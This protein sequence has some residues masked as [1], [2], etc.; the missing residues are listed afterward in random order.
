MVLKIRK[1]MNWTQFPSYDYHR[2]YPYPF[3]HV[4]TFYQIFYAKFKEHKVLYR[5]LYVV[6]VHFSYLFYKYKFLINVQIS[7]TPL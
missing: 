2:D 5:F 4:L 7:P 3:F 1:N 6:Y